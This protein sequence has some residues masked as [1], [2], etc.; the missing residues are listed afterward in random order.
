MHLLSRL[1]A[2]TIAASPLLALAALPAS[3]GG[4][5][6][7]AFTDIQHD[8]VMT[9]ANP[10]PCTGDPGTVTTIE[11][12]VFHGTVNKTGSSFTGTSEGTFSYVPDDP[13][14]PSFTGH[15][16][17]WFGDNLRRGVEVSTFN[18]TGVGSDGSRL[19]FHDNT[20]ATLNPDGT[21]TVTF[22]HATCGG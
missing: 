16:A 1:A 11:N 10:N 17:T 12:Q 14:K 3:A 9:F 7:T 2:A 6:A 5:G 21:V 8:V 15:F 22:D 13:T 20:R 19:E 18:V 4:Q